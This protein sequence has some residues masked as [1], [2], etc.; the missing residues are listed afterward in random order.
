MAFPHF[1]ILI[2]Y[3]SCHDVSLKRIS[4]FSILASDHHMIKT[5]I[6][7]IDSFNSNIEVT[8]PLVRDASNDNTKKLDTL[9]VKTFCFHSSPLAIQLPIEVANDLSVRQFTCVGMFTILSKFHIILILVYL[10]LLLLQFIVTLNIHLSE[11]S[12]M[13]LFGR[14][15]YVGYMYVDVMYTWSDC[16]DIYCMYVDN[17]C[18]K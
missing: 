8:S 17:V 2:L 3:V 1:Q 16:N 7:F 5:Y 14:M 18:I 4:F 10:H 13:I 12:F 9:V 15:L 11:K 6:T